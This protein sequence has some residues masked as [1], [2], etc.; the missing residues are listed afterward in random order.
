MKR[1]NERWDAQLENLLYEI[2][3]SKDAYE[4]L[5]TANK[6]PLKKTF[7]EFQKRQRTD[8]WKILYYKIYFVKRSNT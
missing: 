4:K 8:Y 7:F 2:I 1:D 5:V 6:Y 3:A